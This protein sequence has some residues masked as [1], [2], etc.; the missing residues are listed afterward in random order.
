MKT[1]QLYTKITVYLSNVPRTLDS[2]IIA[3]F[4]TELG[5]IT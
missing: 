1:R 4:A 2:N 3:S 5:G